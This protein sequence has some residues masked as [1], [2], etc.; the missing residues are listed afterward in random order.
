MIQFR[1]KIK[2]GPSFQ[3]AQVE[4]HIFR[5]PPACAGLA[6]R[7]LLFLSDIHLSKRFPAEAVEKL[8]KQIE[9]LS[10]DMILMGGDYAESAAW[11]LQFFEMFSR[12]TPPMGI[13][14]VLG[15]NDYECFDEQPAPLLTAAQRAG[16]TLLVDRTV[17]FEMNGASVSVA[18]LDEFR[19]AK[20]LKKPLFTGKD[21]SSLRILL[22]HYPQSIGRYLREYP[23]H[24]PHLAAAGHTHGGQFSLFGLTPYSIGFEFLIR[25][26]RLPLVAGWKQMGDTHL[27][28]SPGLGT[29]RIPL[30]INVDP[31]IHLIRLAL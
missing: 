22:S 9:A 3:S 29:S 30:R 7:T 27:L 21:A 8:L 17:R 28:V 26:E 14:G 11:Q 1:E 4:E 31:T 25:W 23:V 15:N 5:L 13:F 24:T 16:V 10:P 19:H 2:Y 18:G 20:K 12:L 6:G